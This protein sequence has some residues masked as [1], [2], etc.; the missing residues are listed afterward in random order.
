[1]DSR[2]ITQARPAVPVQFATATASYAHPQMQGKWTEFCGLNCTPSSPN[3]TAMPA[4]EDLCKLPIVDEINNP[5]P[6]MYYPATAVQWGW[7]I[8]LRQHGY[9]K[10]AD[11]PP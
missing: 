2:E 7:C 1:M 10:I 8:F 6:F 9:R 5:S 3:V 4:T 11:Y